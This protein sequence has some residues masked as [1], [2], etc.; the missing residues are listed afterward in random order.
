MFTSQLTAYLNQSSNDF[1]MKLDD[2]YELRALEVQLPGD[3]AKPYQ[4]K[5][6]QRSCANVN[7]PYNVSFVI[8]LLS[9]N[10]IRKDDITHRI[11]PSYPP[12]AE[13]TK[14]AL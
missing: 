1:N 2:F 6:M 9:T 4:I 13:L 12:R 3:I 10:W 5:N 14:G 8:S 7:S 11:Y